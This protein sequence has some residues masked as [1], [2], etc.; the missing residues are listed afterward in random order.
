MPRKAKTTT[1]KTTTNTEPEINYL[2]REVMKQAHGKKEI[3]DE[4]IRQLIGE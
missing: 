1:A 2:L 4:E 3:T